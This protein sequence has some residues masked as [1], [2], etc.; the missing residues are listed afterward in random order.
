MAPFPRLLP[1][2]STR[3]PKLPRRSPPTIALAGSGRMPVSSSRHAALPWLR[4]AVSTWP[5][6]AITAFSTSVRMARFCRSGFLCGYIQSA[7]PVV[8]STS[9]GGWPLR[10]M[11]ASMWPTPGTIASRSSPPM[12]KF[13]MMWGTGPAQG[14]AQFYGP[15]GLV[16]DSLGH[17]FVADTGNKRIVIFDAN[18]NY[19]GEFGTPG[20]QLGQLDE[21]VDIAL[22]SN[23]NAYVTDTW[24]QRIQVFYSGCNPACL[25]CLCRLGCRWLVWQRAGI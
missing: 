9:P 17:V 3:M 7:A 14:N 5:I 20:A 22:D 24:N 4:M 2:R 8:P 13:V 16:V 11:A 6:L 25:Y 1:H 15:R 21:P 10:R 12:G 18:G 23:G 19:L